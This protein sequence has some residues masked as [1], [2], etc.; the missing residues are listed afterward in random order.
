M[1][2]LRSRIFGANRWREWLA[3]MAGGNHWWRMTCQ[4]P[5]WSQWH[6][7]FSPCGHRIM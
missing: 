3:R 7:S 4:R 1:A 6:D 2:L 5:S